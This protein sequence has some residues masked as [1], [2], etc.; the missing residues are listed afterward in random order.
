MDYNKY[1]SEIGIK[2]ILREQAETYLHYTFEWIAKDAIKKENG[3]VTMK[4]NLQQQLSILSQ[5]HKESAEVYNDMASYFGLTDTAFW[6]LYAVIHTEGDCTQ[7]DLSSNWFYPIQTINSAV[8]I[9]VKKG[10]LRLETIPGTR[11]RKR[12][13]LTEEGQAL[14]E[15]SVGK[16]DEIE[17]N[18]FSY[19]SQEEQERYLTLFRRYLENLRKEEE[20]VLGSLSEE[21]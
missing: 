20:R 1:V 21:R 6:I 5:M 15:H 4:P 3:G 16:V 17:R 2:S 10:I 14:A 19:F 18:A 8:S 13:L 9:M 12:I 7:N 11:N